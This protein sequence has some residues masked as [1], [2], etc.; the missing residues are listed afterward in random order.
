MTDGKNTFSIFIY[1]DN[2]MNWKSPWLPAMAG[3]RLNPSTQLSERFDAPLGSA[4]FAFDTVVGN[5]QKK[6]QWIHKLATNLD[7]S[8]ASCYKWYDGQIA[9][10]YAQRLTTR[11]F[12]C[13]CR[14][15]QAFWD[16]RFRWSGILRV[17]SDNFLSV[18]DSRRIVIFIGTPISYFQKCCYDARGA[19]VKGIIPNSEIPT[20][21][22]YVS[23]VYQWWQLWFVR[24]F[25]PVARENALRED[26][27]A[28]RDCCV[29]SDLCQLYEE[30]R[31][32]PKCEK[33]VPPRRGR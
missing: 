7:N 19:L 12:D 27:N 25:R 5:T 16:R 10:Y 4:F 8:A 14:S 32:L 24:Y 20:T 6:G 26:K 11:A 31:P 21:Q 9:N 2:G 22:H 13:P 18:Y 23:I 17:D 15:F 29:N 28:F 3:Y 1:D 30:K 33:Y